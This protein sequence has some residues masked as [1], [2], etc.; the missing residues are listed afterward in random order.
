M[1]GSTNRRVPAAI[2]AEVVTT[3]LGEDTDRHHTIAHEKAPPAWM[4]TQP[5]VASGRF[6]GVEP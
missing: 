3:E 2:E 5:A 6:H 1:T 4:G